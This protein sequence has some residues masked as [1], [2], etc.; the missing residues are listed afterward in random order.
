MSTTSTL[1]ESSSLYRTSP[2]MWISMD[3]VTMRARRRPYGRPSERGLTQLRGVGREERAN[4]RRPPVG[5][6]RRAERWVGAVKSDGRHTV[7][8]YAIARK[9]G[10]ER[11][12]LE[13]VNGRPL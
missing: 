6:S 13:D 8:R 7:W 4:L 1:S 5:T 11:R 2:I 10:E 9:P 3:V 12:R